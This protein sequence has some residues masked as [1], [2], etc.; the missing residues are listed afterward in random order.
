MSYVSFSLKYRPQRFGDVVGQEHVSRTL[1]NALS[2]S[3]VHHAYLFCGPRG[4]GKTSTARVLAKAL[5][6]ATGPTPEPCGECEFCRAVQ[7]GRAMDVI[8]IDAASNRGIDEIRELREKVKYSPAEARS[9]VYILDEVHMLTTE[10]FNALLKTLEEPPDHSFFVLATTEPHKVPAT[11]LSRCQRFDFRPIT[12]ADISALLAKIAQLEDI[13]AD[14]AALEAIA[15]AAD[16]GMRDAESIFDQVV[17]YSAGDVTQQIVNSVLGVTEADTLAQIADVMA[18]SD[19]ATS[20]GLVDRIVAA[21]KDVSQLLADLTIYMR[22]LLRVSLGSEPSV[23][24]LPG[25][26]GKTRMM[27]Q[28]QALG[29]D[30]LM[31]AIHELAQAQG[32]LRSSAQPALVLELT[33][34]KLCRP[35]A[36]RPAPGPRAAQQQTPPRSVATQSGPTQRPQP[37]QPRPTAP[38]AAQPPAPPAAQPPAAPA[39]QP[40]AAQ[41]APP[42]QPVASGNLDLPTIQAHWESVPDELKRMG[43]LPIGA[44]IRV[45]TPTAFADGTV[46]VCFGTQYAFHCNQVQGTYRQVVEEALTR[47]FGQQ[48]AINAYQADSDAESAPKAPQSS[49]PG[50]PH[51]SAPSE[52]PPVVQTAPAAPAPPQP[53]PPEADQTGPAVPAP[54]QPQA[55]VAETPRDGHQTTQPQQEIVDPGTAVADAVG[56]TLSLF[57]GSREI[58]GDE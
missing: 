46:S 22:D 56:G 39:A 19:V 52:G 45:G 8:E 16:G 17:A 1:M 21:G 58:D 15:R 35:P 53:K 13:Q 42:P 30:R 44:F 11:I 55:P 29:A 34:A 12:V 6:C 18:A 36:A 48:L 23:W 10:A 47:L 38:P 49:A 33:L 25:D 57:E 24:T 43:R 2:T 28:A 41:P 40:P 54:I 26:E 32:E 3:R 27:R 4:T 37:V 5:N 51:R 9:K 7:D 31:A 50:R 20:F 14:P